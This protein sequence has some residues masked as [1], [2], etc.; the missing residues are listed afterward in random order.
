MKLAVVAKQVSIKASEPRPSA[1]CSWITSF[2]DLW[3][4]VWDIVTLFID[5]SFSQV[6]PPR[7]KNSSFQRAT[8]LRKQHQ[9]QTVH[10]NGHKLLKV[11]CYDQ[12]VSLKLQN[13]T[14]ILALSGVWPCRQFLF[15]LLKFWDN[16][17]WDFDCHH[18]VME[19]SANLFVLVKVMTNYMR[20]SNMSFHKVR[21]SR[22][23]QLKYLLTF[24]WFGWSDS[25][26]ITFD[27]SEWWRLSITKY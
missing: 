20:K 4:T 9:Q 27:F 24:L 3:Q 23:E 5:P 12:R 6:V 16:Y 18:S 17:L 8:W 21:V 19:L 13:N 22:C 25:L 26:I 14:L 11:K 10:N 1:H 2:T 15:E 7:I